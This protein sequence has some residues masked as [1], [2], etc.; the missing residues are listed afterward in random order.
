MYLGN[1]LLHTEQ[2]VRQTG[3]TWDTRAIYHFRHPMSCIFIVGIDRTGTS[4]RGRVGW[5]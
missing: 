3:R 2:S 1:F 5:P 4:E